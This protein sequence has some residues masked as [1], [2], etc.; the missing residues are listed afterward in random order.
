MVHVNTYLKGVRKTDRQ[1]LQSQNINI[2]A[3]FHVCQKVIRAFISDQCFL[4]KVVLNR[5]VVW[6]GSRL[7]VIV[8]PYLAELLRIGQDITGLIDVKVCGGVL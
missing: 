3:F 6:V 8:K 2:S 5:L 1:F 7:H 4:C